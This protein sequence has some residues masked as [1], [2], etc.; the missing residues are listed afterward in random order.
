VSRGKPALKRKR[1]K[2]ALGVAGASLLLAGGGRKATDDA[3]L[4][5]PVSSMTL[6]APAAGLGMV[7]VKFCLIF[8]IL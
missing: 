5:L 6:Q 1:L 8:G 4:S 2:N 7:A 3:A